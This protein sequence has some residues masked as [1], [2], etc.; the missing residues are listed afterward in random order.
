MNTTTYDLMEDAEA[1]LNYEGI[2]TACE[3]GYIALEHFTPVRDVVSRVAQAARETPLYQSDA[4]QSR[5]GDYLLRYTMMRKETVFMEFWVDYL[6]KL[7]TAPNELHMC[8]TV[9][10]F[11]PLLD[12]LLNHFSD[13]P[14]AAEPK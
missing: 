4:T 9:L 13:T 2:S 6:D 7:V 11:M 10:I 3:A 5:F 12:D 1:L 8:G 14:N